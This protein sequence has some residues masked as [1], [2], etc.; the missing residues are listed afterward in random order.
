MPNVLPQ[1]EWLETQHD[2]GDYVLVKTIALV[3]QPPKYNMPDMR[4]YYVR[5]HSYVIGI[6]PPR[7]SLITDHC[8]R[9]RSIMLEV[10]ANA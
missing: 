10:T 7:D 9:V 4:T 2:N 6:V 8:D 5:S 3:G 1:I